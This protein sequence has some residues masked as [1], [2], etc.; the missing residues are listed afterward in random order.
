MYNLL[1]YIMINQRNHDTEVFY[2]RVFKQ[3]AS[4]SVA[5]FAITIQL[6]A[7]SESIDKITYTREGALLTFP[8]YSVIFKSQLSS[9]QI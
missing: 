5:H 8:A 4:Y 6:L 1:V 3:N 2:V 9:V 7:Y